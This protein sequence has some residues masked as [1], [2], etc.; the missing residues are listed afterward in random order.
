MRRLRGVGI[1][2]WNR[3]GGTFWWH[4][5]IRFKER[6]EPMIILAGGF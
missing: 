2:Y 5:S 1:D 3:S 4:D 6:E